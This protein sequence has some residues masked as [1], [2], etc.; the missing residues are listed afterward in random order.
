MKSLKKSSQRADAATRAERRSLETLVGKQTYGTWV[1]M[2]RRL[3]PDGRTH[4]VSV[5]VAGM[6]QCAAGIAYERFGAKPAKGTM[7][8][9]L[10]TAVD[11]GDPDE[12]TRELSDVVVQLFKDA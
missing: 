8:A 9:S 10:F 11:W 1:D 5:V 7:A 3:V 2:L 12:I 6:L 4:R